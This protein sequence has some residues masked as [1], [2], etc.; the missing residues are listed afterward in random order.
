MFPM[1]GKGLGPEGS[2]GELDFQP[3][4][5]EASTWIDANTKGSTNTNAR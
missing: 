1:I 4:R 2:L 5:P 3:L